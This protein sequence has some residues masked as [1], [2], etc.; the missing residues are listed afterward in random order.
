MKTQFPNCKMGRVIL[1]HWTNHDKVS[2]HLL[3]HSIHAFNHSAN[4]S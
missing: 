4:I 3:I 1:T 2:F